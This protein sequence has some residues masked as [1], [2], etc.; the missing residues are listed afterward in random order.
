VIIHNL[1]IERVAILPNKTDSPLI[2]N[3]NAV[4]PFPVP[5]QGFQAVSRWRSQISQFIRAIQLPQLSACH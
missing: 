3:P 2:V 5:M 1:N 4:L